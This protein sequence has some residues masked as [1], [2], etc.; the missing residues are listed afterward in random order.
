MDIDINSLQQIL[1]S[2]PDIRP[3][4]SIAKLMDFTQNVKFFKEL[5]TKS[6][7]NLHFLCCQHMHYEFIEAGRFVFNFG[8][9]GTKFYIILK[10]RIAVY[11]PVID[12]KTLKPSLQEVLQLGKG[13]AFGELALEQK[14]PRAASIYCIQDSHFGVL[15]K[16]NYKRILLQHVKESQ[17]ESV[18]FLQSLPMFSNYTRD[19]IRKLLFFFKEI[20]YQRNQIVYREGDTSASVF[21]VRSGEFKFV[22]RMV[23]S[24]ANTIQAIRASITEQLKKKEYN[25][26]E[27]YILG[28]GEFFGEEEVVNNTPRDATCICATTYA[29][30]L[31]I[32][33]HDFI[34]KI[35]S[36]ESW[37]YVKSR[38]S[39][40]CK[41]RNK[42]IAVLTQVLQNNFIDCVEGEKEERAITPRRSS[43]P[44][45]QRA[46]HI[47]RAHDDN[48]RSFV[49]KNVERQMH[50]RKNS[51]KELS[52]ADSRTSSPLLH[53][54]QRPSS[55][56]RLRNTLRSPEV[57][58][59]HEM[60]T[61][62]KTGPIFKLSPSPTPDCI[63]TDPEEDAI[64]LAIFSLTANPKG[65]TSYLKT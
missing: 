65:R 64:G 60:H 63:Q 11:V 54:S 56:Q 1:K 51:V 10:G 50:Q 32:S 55:Q 5:I 42:Q 62:F 8:E 20:D 53:R 49:F 16:S 3:L 26:A 28:Q 14:K 39:L 45:T 12:S 2:P 52:R 21:I 4:K 48:K 36:E 33:K 15:D 61:F 35:R 17:M 37:N 29:K 31:S 34:N 41:S 9:K 24:K 40:K 38:I 58:R 44:F 22:K 47:S 25:K 7:K 30:V 57:S 19:T 13:A 46:M 6:S 23:V 18:L 59:S 27:L 43:S